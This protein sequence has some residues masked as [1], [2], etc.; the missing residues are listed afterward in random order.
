[1][2]QSKNERVARVK[3]ARNRRPGRTETIAKLKSSRVTATINPTKI[4][5]NK[6]HSQ[7]LNVS[8]QMG[9]RPSR[10]GTLGVDRPGNQICDILI[11]I[12]SL[13]QKKKKIQSSSQKNK[14]DT[15]RII[16]PL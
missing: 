10:P 2:R 16:R 6:R 13:S 3:I 7:V 8:N 9:N 11:N 5:R 14:K 12:Q 4:A 1:M 15:P